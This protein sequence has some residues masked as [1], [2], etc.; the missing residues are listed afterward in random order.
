MRYSSK[1]NE[2]A[3]R[4]ITTRKDNDNTDV[5]EENK[6]PNF[7]FL[8]RES[9]FHDFT[10]NASKQLDAEI[11]S[12]RSNSTEGTD[13]FEVLTNIFSSELQSETN[14]HL[15]AFFLIV[16]AL[17]LSNIDAMYVSKQKLQKASKQ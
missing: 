14:K 5:E 8:A 12:L 11:E 16:P 9:V 10:I 17:C 2:F 4:T 1:A 3:T 6:H 7:E 15:N 13:Y